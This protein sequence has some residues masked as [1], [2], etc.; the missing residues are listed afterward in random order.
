M[1]NYTSKLAFQRYVQILDIDLHSLLSEQH[2]DIENKALQCAHG[3]DSSDRVAQL[4]GHPAN[5]PRLV[6]SIVTVA[7]HI[8]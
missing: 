4:A 3:I 7:R 1:S 6:G 5:I 2:F 8:R